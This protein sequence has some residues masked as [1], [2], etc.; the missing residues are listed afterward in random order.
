VRN[1]ARELIRN[2]N[3]ND[4]K[5]TDGILNTIEMF[6]RAYD[7]CFGCASHS[8]GTVKLQIDIFDKNRNLITSFKN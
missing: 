5:W 6:F 7:P 1:A 4:P 8:L 3:I 2:N